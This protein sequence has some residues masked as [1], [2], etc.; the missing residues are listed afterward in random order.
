MSLGELVSGPDGPVDILMLL[1]PSAYKHVQAQ[2][3]SGALPADTFLRLD[4]VGDGSLTQ[5]VA[6]QNS[7]RWQILLELDTAAGDNMRLSLATRN[8]IYGEPPRALL[9]WNPRADA[10]MLHTA[11]DVPYLV[12]PDLVE[13]IKARRADE[14]KTILVVPKDRRWRPPEDQEQAQCQRIAHAVW[15]VLANRIMPEWLEPSA[16]ADF[17]RPIKRGSVLDV[18]SGEAEMRRS[19]V[20]AVALKTTHIK[21]VYDESMA[22]GVQGIGPVGRQ[23][24]RKLLAEEYPELH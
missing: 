7:R 4:T 13:V 3:D 14:G 5:T 23:D 11:Y 17:Y 8:L 12:K 20:G 10:D 1:E 19:I 18:G 6:E 16:L 21:S 24:L 22:T 15:R 9:S 2:V